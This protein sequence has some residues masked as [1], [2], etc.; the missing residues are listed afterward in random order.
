MY[1]GDGGDAGP[2]VVLVRCVCG[3]PMLSADPLHAL[4][5]S[6]L[7][8]G[9]DQRAARSAATAGAAPASPR[10]S[11][12]IGGPPRA[13]SSSGIGGGG[14][15]RASSGNA[16]RMRRAL[17]DELVRCGMTVRARLCIGLPRR[18]QSVDAGSCS[19]RCG[20]S[21]ADVTPRL[22]VQRIDAAGRGESM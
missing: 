17:I 9:L 4:P 3:R 19:A 5:P 8:V 13:R 21:F 10:L 11:A 6:L 22:G 14:E 12:G 2:G 1:G 16:S 15:S 20:D 7:S 18:A